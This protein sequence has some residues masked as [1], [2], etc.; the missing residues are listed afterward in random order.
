MVLY[1]RWM[2]QCGACALRIFEMF[3]TFCLSSPRPYLLVMGNPGWKSEG[4]MRCSVR[5][6]AG[7]RLAYFLSSTMCTAELPPSATP[8]LRLLLLSTSI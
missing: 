6:H 1:Y 8:T 3:P 7:G 5:F 4:M 2:Q